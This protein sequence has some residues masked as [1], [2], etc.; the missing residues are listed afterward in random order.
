MSKSKNNSSFNAS[1][2]VADALKLKKIKPSIGDILKQQNVNFEQEGGN[3]DNT[4]QALD[5]AEI[6]PDETA[7]EELS[8]QKQDDQIYTN[9]SVK[10]APK[11][12]VNSEITKYPDKIEI[13]KII[14][15]DVTENFPP[16]KRKT[17]YS[18]DRFFIPNRNVQKG[19]AV[20]VRTEYH[21]KIEK[22]VNSIGERGLTLAAYIDNILTVHFEQFDEEIS[23]KHQEALRAELEALNNKI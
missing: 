16:R 21:T 22:I 14:K 2:L 12:E 9:S 13:E 8:P 15:P 7:R 23:K 10:I 11:E 17:S 19:K 5:I 3:G 4:M 20:Y 18:L 6:N 1:S